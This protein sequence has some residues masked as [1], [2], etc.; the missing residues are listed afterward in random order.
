MKATSIAP[1]EL[2]DPGKR[3]AT[4]CFLCWALAPPSNS[5]LSRSS[6]LG[7]HRHIVRRGRHEFDFCRARVF[8]EEWKTTYME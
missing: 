5:G 8:R 2:Q 4:Q 7:S 6:L 1:R 3:H